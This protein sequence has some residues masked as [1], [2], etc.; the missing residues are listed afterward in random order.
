[1]KSIHVPRQNEPG[2]YYGHPGIY[3]G[4]RGVPLGRSWAVYAADGGAHNRHTLKALADTE[5]EAAA[6]AADLIRSGGTFALPFHHLFTSFSVPFHSPN[7]AQTLVNRGDRAQ[8]FH[9]SGE[10]EI[11]VF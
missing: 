1:M 4:P 8:P 3:I 6:I 10:G 2:P 9:C 11:Y 7:P 5:D